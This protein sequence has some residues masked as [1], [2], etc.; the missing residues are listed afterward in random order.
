M[1]ESLTEFEFRPDTNTNTRDICPWESEKVMYYVVSTLAP[2]FLI[3]SSLYLQINEDIY[4]IPDEF[5][6]WPDR[7]KDC[8]VS[9]P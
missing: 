4:N 3:G 6:I 5:E 7:T 1:H 8:G 9:Y 2:S